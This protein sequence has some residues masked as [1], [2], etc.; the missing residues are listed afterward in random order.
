MRKGYFQPR[1]ISWWKWSILS[2]ILL[3][4]ICFIYGIILYQN[5]QKSKTVGMADSKERILQDTEI[6]KIDS[7]ER[8][9]GVNSYHIAFGENKDEEKKIAFIPLKTENEDVILIDE[10]DI[11]SK[12]LVENQW[13]EQCN[14]CK[15]IKITPGIVEDNE[16]WELTY[17]DESNLYIIDYISMYDGTPYEQFRFTKMFK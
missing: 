12:E 4:I 17:V 16:L 14:Q 8:F 13:K 3:L 15:L 1:Y 11:M 7:I 6:T 2:L 10:S 9:N 5:T